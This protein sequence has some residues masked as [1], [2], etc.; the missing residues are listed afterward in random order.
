MSQ[1]HL[2]QER[3]ANPAVSRLLVLAHADDE[4]LFASGLV[5]RYPGPWTLVCCSIPYNEPVRAWKFF[6][7]C[8]AMGVQGRLIPWAEKRNKPL[9]HLE[10]LNPLLDQAGFVVTHGAVGEYGHAGHV[11]VH[12][13]IAA[14]CPEK[15]LCIGFGMTGVEKMAVSLT[16]AEW[17]RKLT[18][19]R[20]YNQTMRWNGKRMPVYEALLEQYHRLNGPINL[21]EECYYAPAA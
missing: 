2:W 12:R 1:L 11:S 10:E 4:S 7:A 13:H 6:D 15:M 5:L 19:L 18:V 8:A 21:R 20:S 14:R 3:L 9:D 17:E 16:D